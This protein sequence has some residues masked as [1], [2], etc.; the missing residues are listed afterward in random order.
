MSE[1][2]AAVL[3]RVRGG[4]PCREATLAHDFSDLCAI[5]FPDDKRKLMDMRR[6]G[7]VE[8]VAGGADAAGIAAKMANS[9]GR[10]NALHKTM[11]ACEHRG[12]AQ[13]RCSTPE[14]ATRDVR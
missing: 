13:H 14:G 8:A 2:L 12:R 7:T 10:S 1:C 3:F 6:P 9:I 4:S 5:V 11:C